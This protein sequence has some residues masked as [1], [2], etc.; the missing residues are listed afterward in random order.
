VDLSDSALIRIVRSDLQLTMGL[1][2]SPAFVHLIRHRRGIPQ[3]LVGHTNRLAGIEARLQEQP[4]LFL[5]GNSYRGVSINAC[6]S[7]APLVAAQVANHLRSM[8]VED[9]YAVGVR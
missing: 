5:A 2:V 7:D 4:G 6:I 3:Y 1:R 9:E 8:T